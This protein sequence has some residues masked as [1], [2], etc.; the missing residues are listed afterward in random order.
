MLIHSNSLHRMKTVLKWE[1]WIYQSENVFN[2]EKS[3]YSVSKHQRTYTLTISKYTA[4]QFAH[5]TEKGE[6]GKCFSIYFSSK[7]K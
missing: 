6:L 7:R 4:I 3:D 5:C 1:E 2:R